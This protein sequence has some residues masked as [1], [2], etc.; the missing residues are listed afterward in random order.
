R[1][2]AE[3]VKSQ[4]LAALGE[5]A[6][7]VAHEVRNP[8]AAISG[9]LQILSDDLKQGDPHKELM[10]EILGQVRRLDRTVRG[11]LAFS[12]PTTPAKQAIVLQDFIERIA[13]LTGESQRGIRIG[14]AGPADLTLSADPALLEQVLWNLFLNAMEAMKGS[15]QIRVSFQATAAGIDLAITDS[16]GGIPP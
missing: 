6:A 2:D 9:P 14:Y 11:L 3:M 12:K 1:M 4:S 10:Q 8:L 7:T 5:M 15:G 16:G 13:R